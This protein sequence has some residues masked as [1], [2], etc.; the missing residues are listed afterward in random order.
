MLQ[1]LAIMKLNIRSSASFDA[2]IYCRGK[3]KHLNVLLSLK[4]GP[5]KPHI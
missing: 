1:Y 2:K 3:L 5:E 4:E